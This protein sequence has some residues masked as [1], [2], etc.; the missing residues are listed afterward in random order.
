[1]DDVDC[2]S[3]NI[4][5]EGTCEAALS[6]PLTPSPLV[7]KGI[8]HPI[9]S[10]PTVIPFDQPDVNLTVHG[11]NIYIS[12]THQ[13]NYVGSNSFTWTESIDGDDAVKSCTQVEDT[14]TTQYSRFAMATQRN[15]PTE[16]LLIAHCSLKQQP[17][18]ASRLAPLAI[19]VSWARRRW[20]VAI[21]TR[22]A[23]S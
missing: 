13:A 18:A 19:L 7:A 11:V 17:T 6:I 5:N 12:V 3:P 23:M 8:D 16:A 9:S 10:T 22:K 2:T 15:A 1:M 4:C 21:T 14:E 20:L